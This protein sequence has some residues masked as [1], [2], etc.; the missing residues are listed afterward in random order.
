MISMRARDATCLLSGTLWLDTIDSAFENTA[1]FF[2]LMLPLVRSG[3]SFLIG[4]KRSTSPS[5]SRSDRTPPERSMSAMSCGTGQPDSNRG[6]RYRSKVLIRQRPHFCRARR[7]GRWR[8]SFSGLNL[9]ISPIVP[10]PSARV[11]PPLRFPGVR[12]LGRGSSWCGGV[13][14]DGGAVRKRVKA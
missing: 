10:S 13:V 3:P 6:F 5:G 1:L 12:C 14:G 4:E 9:L 8:V 11:L 7:V 2:A